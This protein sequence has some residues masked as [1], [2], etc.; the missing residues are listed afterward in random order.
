MLNEIGH[1]D[2]I[3]EYVKKARD[4]DD[5]FRLF[6]FGHRVYKNYDPRAKVMQ[7]T[8]HEVLADLGVEDPLLE[9][10]MALEKIA[11]KT[12]ISSTVS[13]IPTSISTP[14]LF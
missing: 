10:A 13:S 14:A 2:R 11:L 12:S 4:K 8:C 6:G 9:L 5:P 3:G 7:A 1:I